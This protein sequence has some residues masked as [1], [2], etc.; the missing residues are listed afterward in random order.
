M[1]EKKKKKEMYS[2]F[3]TIYCTVKKHKYLPT[4]GELLDKFYFFQ[5]TKKY[6]HYKPNN[7]MFTITYEK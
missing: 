5:L 3:K 1:K 4:K 7:Y 2:K 6:K